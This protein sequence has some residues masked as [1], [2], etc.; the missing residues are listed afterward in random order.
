MRKRAKKK[1]S[2]KGWK[3]KMPKITKG[4]WTCHKKPKVKDDQDD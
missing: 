1:A 4:C 3:K 2:S